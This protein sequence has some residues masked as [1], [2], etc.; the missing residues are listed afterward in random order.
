MLTKRTV[1]G[2]GS[3]FTLIELL[4]VIA[5]IAI[6][7]AMLL[8]ALSSA[9]L[10]ATEASCQ[11]NQKQLIEAFV[12]YSGDFRD[13]M[14]ASIYENQF[15]TGSGFYIYTQVPT[16][17]SQTTA[18]Q[19]V[20]QMLEKTCPFFSYAPNYKTYHCP[21]DRRQFLEVGKGWAYISYSKANGMGYS[22][23]A[24]YWDDQVPY[25]LLGSV[26]TPSQA[27][28]FVEEADPRGY[29]EG[30]WVCDRSTSIGDTVWVDNFAIFHGIVS[31]FA[32]TD[33]H[34]EGH[35]W[36]NKQLINSEQQ[37]SQGNF[38]GYYAPGGDA[39]DPDYVWI[40]NGYRFVN[41][42]ALE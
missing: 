25:K 42:E 15:Y 12:M 26:T 17:I 35:S 23:T 20:A 31:T 27:F 40:W 6:L 3:A 1:A 32:F 16:G 8:P 18:E 13:N 34:V 36:L 14:P 37:V 22:D 41:W 21:S 9:K 33:G 2:L 28:V 38:G 30:T 11:N 19:D 29:N 4:V 7:A 24:N 5:I 39:H 10:K